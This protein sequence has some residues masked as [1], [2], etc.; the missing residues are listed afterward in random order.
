MPTERGERKKLQRMLAEHLRD[1]DRAKLRELRARIHSA[2][3]KRKH[4][5]THAR[6]AC[7]TARLALKERQQSERE[8]FRDQQ[9][10]KRVEGRTACELG[11]AGAK[12]RGKRAEAEAKSEL[13]AERT[14]QRQVRAADAR[15]GKMRSTA[16]ERRLESDDEVRANIPD[17]L[18]PVFDS[19]KK[20]IKGGP[21]KSRTESFLEWA[22]ENPEE[23]VSLQQADA[24]AYLAKLLR[25]QRE[26]GKAMRKTGRYR[27]SV[28][29]LSTA[30]LAEA[31]F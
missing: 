16:R 14:L 18:V 7:R 3:V 20:Q 23:I 19:V 24:D 12:G 8:Q 11:K 31:P 28:E 9:R 25:E 30:L 1:K 13:R 5:L 17:N 4:E 26:H 10:E 2:R 27:Q 29:D 15:G 22:E 6:Q 21:R